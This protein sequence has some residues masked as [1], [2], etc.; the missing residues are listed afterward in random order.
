MA[1]IEINFFRN[2]VLEKYS[3]GTSKWCDGI[4]EQNTKLWGNE[5]LNGNH[6]NLPNIE[7]LGC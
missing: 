6:R 5:I 7:S 4:D 3:Y 2:P 1:A